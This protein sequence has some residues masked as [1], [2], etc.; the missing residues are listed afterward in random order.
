V[1]A[2]ALRG[3]IERKRQGSRVIRLQGTAV[4]LGRID[5]N[6]HLPPALAQMRR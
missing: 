5:E 2:K 4:T 6:P 3:L 1:R